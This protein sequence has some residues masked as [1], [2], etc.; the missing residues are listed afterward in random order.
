MFW[1]TRYHVPEPQQQEC[2]LR[3]VVSWGRGWGSQHLRVTKYYLSF[4]LKS[5]Q[6]LQEEGIIISFMQQRKLSL[7]DFPRSCSE[8]E[9]EG[10]WTHCCDTC[11]VAGIVC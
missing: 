2:T 8:E 4:S 3:V 7:R 5:S 11:N 9:G 10:A 1:N 6:Q